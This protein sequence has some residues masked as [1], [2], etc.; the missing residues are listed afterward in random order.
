M[1]LLWF[2]L[3]RTGHLSEGVT[4]CMSVIRTDRL[5]LTSDGRFEESRRKL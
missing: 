5:Y 2:R 3:H 1:T 4:M